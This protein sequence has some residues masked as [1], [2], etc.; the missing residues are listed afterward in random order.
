MMGPPNGVGC[1]KLPS[2]LSMGL[3]ITTH[4]LVFVLIVC[5]SYM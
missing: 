5:V 1:G 3:C 2:H 4:Q